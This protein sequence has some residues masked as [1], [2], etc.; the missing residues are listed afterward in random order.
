MSHSTQP[1]ES[2][3]VDAPEGPP[4]AALPVAPGRARHRLAVSL[5]QWMREGVLIAVSAALGFGAAQYGEYRADREHAARVLA[6]IEAEMARNLATLE[7]FVPVHQGWV[8]AIAND[9]RSLAGRSA[10]D[11]FIGLR[12]SLPPGTESSFP[13]LRRSAWDAAVAGDALR[14]MD[15]AVV[16]ELSETYRV[17]EI[18]MA[19]VE[20]RLAGGA[21]SSAS[22]FDP[23]SREASMKLLQFTLVDILYSERALVDRYQLDLPRV[24]AAAVAAR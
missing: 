1:E 11:A 18:A 9:D 7:P 17:Q 19:N 23:A 4:P 12:P 22:S 24:R 6:G 14:L 10:F 15:Y 13:V 16:A 8:Q 3:S 20:R 2:A 5:P 21:L